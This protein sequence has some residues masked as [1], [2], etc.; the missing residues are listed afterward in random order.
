MDIR[1]QENSP[2]ILEAQYNHHPNT[3]EE[4]TIPVTVEEAEEDNHR[5]IRG[6]NL[7]ITSDKN[8]NETMSRIK[9]TRPRHPKL[10]NSDINA[11]NILPYQ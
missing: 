5:G 7:I 9:V 6:E 10:I 3:L 2:D 1:R 4:N 11:S 8:N